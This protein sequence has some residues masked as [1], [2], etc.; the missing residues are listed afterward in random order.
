VYAKACGIIGKSFVGSRIANLEPAGRLADLDRLVF[1][2]SFRE[3]PERELLID[4][5]RRIIGRSADQ[6]ISIVNSYAKPPEFLVRLLRSYEYG[7]LKSVLAAIAGREPK[8]PA[9][10]N[11]GR[12]GVVKFDAYPDLAA[13]V[14][15]TEF[16]FLLSQAP[17]QSEGTITLQT[18]LDKQ[19]YTMLWESLY[20]LK[21]RDRTGIEAILSEEISLRNVA[22]MLRLRTYYHMTADQIR[23]KLIDVKFPSSHKGTE[24]K[25]RS[26][27]A[28][29]EAA[30]ELPLDTYA[31]WASWKRASFLNPGQ[32]D[33]WTADPRYFQNMASRH[34]YQMARHYFH[35][36]PFSIDTAAC[37]IKLKQFEEDLLTSIAEGLG[38]GMTSR[39]VFALLEIK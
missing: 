36:R 16:E 35:R 10:T 7:D 3:L 39:D 9:F 6:I 29:A 27:A 12:F 19:Y 13:M 1:P 28:D 34:L 17:I 21:R 5:E 4:L 11:L 8:A 33:T 2:Q 38:I 14:R 20:Y 25:S 32:I 24:G 37:F 15:G 22:W 26:M 30:I 31:P 18:K 23:E